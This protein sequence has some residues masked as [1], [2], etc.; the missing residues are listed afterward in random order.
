MIVDKIEAYLKD[1][2]FQ[3][4]DGLRYELEKIAGYTFKKQFMEDR[5]SQAGGK[6]YI[7]AAGK[8]PRQLAYKFHAIEEDGKEMDARA[9]LVFW[10]G[11]LIEFTVV[12]LAKLAGVNLT[13]TGMNQV[14]V[15]RR[16]A[17]PDPRDKKV[18]HE[19]II[20]GMADGLI[21]NDEQKGMGL[22]EVK[23]MSDYA[24]KR[25]EKGEVD[26]DYLAQANVYLELLGLYWCCFVGLCKSNGVMHEVVI[27]K[28]E[29]VLN[30][31]RANIKKVVLST[32]ENLPEPPAEYGPDKN[33]Y[34]TWNCLYCAFWKKCRPGAR[35]V[36]VKNSY[37]L[38]EVTYGANK[39]ANRQKD[40]GATKRD[41][42]K[43]RK[44]TAGGAG[45]GKPQGD[46]GAGAGA[47]DTPGKSGKPKVDNPRAGRSRRGSN[48]QTPPG[49]DREGSGG[50]KVETSSGQVQQ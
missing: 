35:Q 48:V 29:K 39:P 3:V 40:P 32:P 19:G 41:P 17:L 15:K 9:K 14:Y 30:R 38:Q 11:D 12:G 5:K 46:A 13:A 34:Y 8:C 42:Q 16:L 31:V 4:N 23:S 25:F 26:Q 18:I 44:S 28:D 2:D 10:T 36:L 50:Q 37:K 47:P 1:K 20:S 27:T 7:S 6:I 21:L 24:F 45:G 22:L 43:Q 49:N 33:G